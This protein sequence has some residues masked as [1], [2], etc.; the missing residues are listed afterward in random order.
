[1]VRKGEEV[2]TPQKDATAHIYHIDGRVTAIEGQIGQIS[3]QLNRMESSLLS[4]PP[5][6]NMN[7]IMTLMLMVAGLLYGISGFVD[8]RMSN[9]K[10][11]TTL[12]TE[13]IAHKQEQI[14]D[15]QEF[16][17]EMHY[18]IGAM[19]KALDVQKEAA[20]HADTLFHELDA[21]IRETEMGVARGLSIQKNL[22]KH[23]LEIDQH[24][25]RAWIGEQEGI[26][27]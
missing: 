12:N 16:Q 11:F 24:G 2:V 17:R 22:S 27:R 5:I 14:K 3:T 21:R 10:E 8:I 18:E 9:M 6:W 7:N 25:S 15:L 1:M 20:M 4:K 13:D 23:I 26:P 19:N